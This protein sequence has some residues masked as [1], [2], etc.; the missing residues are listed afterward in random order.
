MTTNDWLKLYQELNEILDEFNSLYR[1]ANTKYHFK[2]DREAAN[3]RLNALMN[4]AYHKIIRNSDTLK[5][6]YNDL[7][8]A[9]S[10]YIK[11]SNLKIPE[12]FSISLRSY[13]RHIEEHIM[14]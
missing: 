12:E 13:L 11:E 6:L 4:I 1:P 10:K 9:T 14:I 3:K 5:L 7:E 8:D 2:K